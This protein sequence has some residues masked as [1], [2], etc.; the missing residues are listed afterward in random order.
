MYGES[1]RCSSFSSFFSSLDTSFGAHGS[2]FTATSPSPSRVVD[3]RYTIP[4]DPLPSSSCSVTSS[5]V[6]RSRRDSRFDSRDASPRDRSTSTPRARTL[7]DASR[8][9]AL[10]V[11]E[12]RV[13]AGR[14][15]GGVAGRRIVDR[16]VSARG[17]AAAPTSEKLPA[18]AAAA[19]VDGGLPFTSVLARQ[20]HPPPPTPCARRAPVYERRRRGCP[21]TAAHRRRRWRPPARGGVARKACGGWILRASVQPCVAAKLLREHTSR[22]HALRAASAPRSTTTEL[23][24]QLQNHARALPNRAPRRS[25]SHAR[26]RAR[27]GR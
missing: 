6:S 23:A 4:Y 18:P 21:S 12:R 26:G 10:E 14:E 24:H 20:G 15:V 11:G 13:A 9:V 22:V 25:A 2:T 7:V 17:P 27:A 19:L 16:R 8:D 5:A 3:A 1:H